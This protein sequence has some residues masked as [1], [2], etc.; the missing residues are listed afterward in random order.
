MITKNLTAIQFNRSVRVIQD[1][2]ATSVGG[3][4]GGIFVFSDA[5]GLVERWIEGAPLSANIVALPK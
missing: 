3:S 5:T 4:G 1:N 2:H